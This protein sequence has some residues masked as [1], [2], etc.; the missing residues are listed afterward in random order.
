MDETQNPLLKN[1]SLEV[2]LL[3]IVYSLLAG[4]D[5]GSYKMHN[6][7]VYPRFL[8]QLEKTHE[9]FHSLRDEARFPC[10]VSRAIAFS[11]SNT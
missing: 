6:S 5:N 2:S 4:Q 11:Q 10:I 7:R 1:G 9:T 8:P 3:P